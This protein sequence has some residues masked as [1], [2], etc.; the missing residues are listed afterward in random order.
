MSPDDCADLAR[1]VLAAFAVA[2]RMLGV[3]VVVVV[4]YVDMRQQYDDGRGQ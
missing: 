2:V 1:A 4:G 3:H